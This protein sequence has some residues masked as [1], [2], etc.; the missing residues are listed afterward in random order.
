MTNSNFQLRA[1][2]ESDFEDWKVMWGMYLD[3]YETQLPEDIYTTTFERLLAKDITSQNAIVAVLGD[4]MVGLVH[5]IFHP[6]NW[7]IED[8][9]YL[10]DLYVLDSVRGRGVGRLLIESVYEEADRRGTPTVYWLT[11][12]FN[13]TARLLYD[14]IAN[15]TPFIKYN[16]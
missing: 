13:K 2:G 9:C 1:L 5:F 8:V 11:Q 15:V 16:R 6:H 3:F 14:K 4:R 12:D 10:Q 7:K